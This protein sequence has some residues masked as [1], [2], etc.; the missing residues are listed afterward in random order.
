MLC[1]LHSPQSEAD[2][3]TDVIDLLHL[4]T[5]PHVPHN[6]FPWALKRRLAVEVLNRESAPTWRVENG[7]CMWWC[8]DVSGRC[9]AVVYFWVAGCCV[10]GLPGCVAVVNNIV[11]SLFCTSRFSFVFHETWQSC[12]QSFFSHWLMIGSFWFW[13]AFLHCKKN[14]NIHRKYGSVFNF[15]FDVCVCVLSRWDISVRAGTEDEHVAA[16]DTF[17]AHPSVFF[18]LRAETKPVQDFVCNHRFSFP[19]SHPLARPHCFALYLSL[20]LSHTYAH[21]Q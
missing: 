8:D 6:L 14:K 2:N 19:F 21:T 3:L 4:S 7:C 11:L 13:L 17:Q 20:L 1:S 10:V 16:F 12:M 5:Y 15:W 18:S 9:A